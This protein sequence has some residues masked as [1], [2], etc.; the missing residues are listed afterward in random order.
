MRWR[1]CSLSSA[2]RSIR[3]GRDSTVRCRS[4]N[5]THR[6]WRSAVDDRRTVGAAPQVKVVRPGEG[7]AGGLAPG[8]GVVF[9][10]DGSDAGGALSIVEHPFDVGAL[11]PP[12]VHTLEDEISVVLE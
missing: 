6:I 8:I 1:V 11:V 4:L 7:L 3:Y 5:L 10:I 12:H 2:R 9:K